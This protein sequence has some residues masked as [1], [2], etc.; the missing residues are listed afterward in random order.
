MVSRILLWAALALAWPLGAHAACTGQYQPGQVCG[1][2]GASQA[3]PRG[4]SISSILDRGIG[5]TRGSLMERGASGWTLL[6]PGSVAGQ[7]LVSAGTGNDPLYA[8]QWLIGPA[9]GAFYAL[10]AV[11]GDLA[12][13]TINPNQIAINGSYVQV[14][15]ATRT[16]AVAANI[17]SSVTTISTGGY[18]TVGDFGGT[19]YQ[20]GAGLCSFTSADGRTWSVA[21]PTITPQM[22]GAFG[23]GTIDETVPLQKVV[24]DTR[25]LYIPLGNYKITAELD[26][27]AGSTKVIMG[28]G[29]INSSVIVMATATQNGIVRQATGNAN[30]SNGSGFGNL[31]V[32]HLQIQPITSG[33]GQ[34][35][36]SA[37]LLSG[38]S[39]SFDYIND[40]SFQGTGSAP[41]FVCLNSIGSI[42]P[43][44]TNNYFFHCT[45]NASGVGINLGQQNNVSGGEFNIR[46]NTFDSSAHSGTNISW[47]G[48]TG[49]SSSPCNTGT[50]IIA[51]NRIQQGAIGIFINPG[52][53]ISTSAFI[54][55]NNS[56][57]GQT[58]GAIIG[59]RVDPNTGIVNSINVT[60]NRF[61]IGSGLSAGS[62]LAITATSTNG[63]V[64]TCTFTNNMV[65]FASTSPISLND[66]FYATI[67][68]NTFTNINGAG[69]S[70]LPIVTIQAAQPSLQTKFGLNTINNN[71][72]GTGFIAPW[73]T[74]SN[75]SVII[76]PFRAASLG[77]VTAVNTLSGVTYSTTALNSGIISRGGAQTAEFTDTTPTAAQIVASLAQS[78]SG[79]FFTLTIQNNTG[80]FL[81]L[82]GGTNVNGGG[83]IGRI[84]SGSQITFNVVITT[85]TRGSESVTFT[86]VETSDV[87]AAWTGLTPTPTCA[88]GSFVTGTASITSGSTA[89]GSGGSTLT[90]ATMG[91]G[92][93]YPGDVVTGGGGGGIT[94]TATVA[95]Y[96]TNGTTG[97]G[98]GSGVTYW[99]VSTPQTVGAGAMTATH[100]TASA[101]TR[102]KVIGKTAYVYAQ[103]SMGVGCNSGSNYIII[104]L[105]WTENAAGTG[106]LA[107]QNYSSKNVVLGQIQFGDN[108][109]FLWANGFGLPGI[110]GD[111][112]IASGTVELQ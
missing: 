112:I 70:A 59:N 40:V 65:E 29:R 105:P 45:D 62:I 35:A 85:A 17:P 88:V 4:S 20:V 15:Y 80:Y 21:S 52:T 26:Y 99:L 64:T 92:T 33:S 42:S 47:G 61:F 8:T 90:V 91:A 74:N 63:W 108:R 109:V 25:P 72:D 51:D 66:C 49:C 55:S 104:P 44:I 18:A 95:P 58:N 43:T 7:I 19:V 39:S 96:G 50:V 1:N 69:T 77:V 34:S 30:C 48:T 57:E 6:T 31:I 81:V 73:V 37:I 67:E 76:T 79:M 53:Y 10:G 97:T 102:T 75:P 93:I 87:G 38:G 23:G 41:F 103:I 106:Q 36:G 86:A 14:T 101:N 100:P 12:A 84:G 94:G 98:I 56:F 11:G 46:G 60:G 111:N 71:S 83:T 107:A 22:C 24:C 32:E 78:F 110:G 9:N 3:D 82:H 28:L 89:S 13:G 54:I 2:S 68:G 16:V 27:T 5:S